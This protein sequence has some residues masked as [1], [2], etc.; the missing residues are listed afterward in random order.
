MRLTLPFIVILVI[1]VS[2]YSRSLVIR[3]Q[4]APGRCSGYRSKRLKIGPWSPHGSEKD[5]SSRSHVYRMSFGGGI[6]TKSTDS[7]SSGS[8]FDE[9]NANLEDLT[10]FLDTLPKQATKGRGN[11][12]A[13]APA[14]SGSQEEY[15]QPHHTQL[16][17]SVSASSKESIEV[18]VDDD[19]APIDWILSRRLPLNSRRFYRRAIEEGRVRINGKI[20][21]S[22]VRVRSGATISVEKSLEG[23]N[24]GVLGGFSPTVLFP[25]HLPEMAVVYEDKHLFA[26]WKPAGMV[27]QPCEAAKSGTVLHGLLYHMI[28]HGQAKKGDIAAAK[29]LSQGIVHRLDRHTSGMMI[30]AKVRRTPCQRNRLN[31]KIKLVRLVAEVEA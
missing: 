27:C 19:H 10:D 12:V 29:T 22:L 18:E 30:V 2:H 8:D 14:I 4:A 9:G 13:T 15:T 11:R 17:S 3:P 24:E 23:G 20:V 7:D 16:D 25:Q 1:F 21:R 31:H 5:H 6:R 26:V 28:E